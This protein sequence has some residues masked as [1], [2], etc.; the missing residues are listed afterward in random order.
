MSIEILYLEVLLIN[1]F[2]Q[3]PDVKL[4]Y[5]IVAVMGPSQVLDLRHGLALVL[6]LESMDF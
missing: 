6:V 3:F 5:F 1:D 2:L 4:L